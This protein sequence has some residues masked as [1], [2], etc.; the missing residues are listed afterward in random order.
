METTL[1]SEN[2]Q[3]AKVEQDNLQDSLK[4]NQMPLFELFSVQSNMIRSR[5]IAQDKTA[6]VLAQGNESLSTYAMLSNNAKK[7]YSAPRSVHDPAVT[8]F[9]C[10]LT[11][12]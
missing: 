5:K 6:P 8:L 10:Q 9:L 3:M 11:H 2:S 7:R 4:K 1:D 12:E